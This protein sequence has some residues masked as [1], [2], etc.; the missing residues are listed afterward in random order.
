MTG[1]FGKAFEVS[2]RFD[3]CVCDL[4][5]T[6]LLEFH[7]LVVAVRPF[8]ECGGV[9][10]G[11]HLKPDLAGLPSDA[12]LTGGLP[13]EDVIRIHRTGS[14]ISM[15]MMR[16]LR[17]FEYLYAR[18]RYASAGQKYRK[19]LRFIFRSLIRVVVLALIM[20]FLALARSLTAFFQRGTQTRTID[21]TATVTI[22][23]L[24]GHDK[25]AAARAENH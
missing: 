12:A 16:K 22:E 18:F 20:P 4:S 25:V 19:L 2:P 10:I 9:I 13:A 15:P 7:L 11:F 23:V 21:A 1:N 6:E 17:R 5:L 8:M 3:I 14:G 24:I